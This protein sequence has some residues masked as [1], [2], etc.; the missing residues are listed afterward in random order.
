MSVKN[1]NERDICSFRSDWNNRN[2]LDGPLRV[3][4]NELLSI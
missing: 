4:H 1:D 2:N 3:K